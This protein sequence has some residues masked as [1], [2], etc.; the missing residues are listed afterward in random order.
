MRAC[1]SSTVAASGWAK[2]VRTIVATKLRALFG[3]RVLTIIRE[4][5]VPRRNGHWREPVVPLVADRVRCRLTKSAT[6][7]D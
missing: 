2:I 5:S 1:C 4:R 7:A 3:T 6:L